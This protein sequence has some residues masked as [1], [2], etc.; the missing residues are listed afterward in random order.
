MSKNPEIRVGVIKF[1]TDTGKLQTGQVSGLDGELLDNI[2]FFQNYGLSAVP[3]PADGGKGSEVILARSG[4]SS[5]MIGLVRDDRRFRPV[6][7]AAGDV[8]LYSWLDNP[9]SAH[10]A[11]K[12]RIALSTDGGQRKIIIRASNGIETEILVSDEGQITLTVGS[13]T[14]TVTES[15]VSVQSQTVTVNASTVAV[16]GSSVSVTG[17]NV[18]VSGTNCSVTGSIGISGPV[19]INGNLEVT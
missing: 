3:R 11:A 12:H 8:M 14:V 17:E 16:N 6:A 4:S 9:Q 5:R 18:T 10:I 7:S 19:S 2:E 13:S 1:A 15:T